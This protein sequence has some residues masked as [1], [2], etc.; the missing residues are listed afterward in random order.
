MDV[1]LFCE[2]YS[3]DV[4][5]TFPANGRFTPEQRRVYE[6]LLSAQMNLIAEVRPGAAAIDIERSALLKIV[7][8][9]QELGVL[10]TEADLRVGA[11]F[12][13]HGLS[14]HVGCANHDMAD[15]T[16]RSI[17]DHN[18]RAERLEPG[19]VITIEPGIYFNMDRLDEFT[20]RN[21]KLAEIINREVVA[22]LAQ[23]VGGIRIEDDVLVTED[24]RE[25]LSNC[26]KTVDELEALFR[27]ERVA[28]ALS[29]QTGGTSHD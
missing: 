16:S 1:G 11:F 29:S 17:A 2:H 14:H 15:F 26:P 28:A 3:G 13:P 23:T 25:V 20:Q 12:M 10:S 6:L 7:R 8:I 19:M 4:S 22:R 27:S 9:C 18:A 5:R 21:P 24:G